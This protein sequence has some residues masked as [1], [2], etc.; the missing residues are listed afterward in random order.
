MHLCHGHGH[1]THLV[2]EALA[3]HVR[4]L[5]R[6]VRDRS[7]GCLAPVPVV[8]RAV[9]L[10]HELGS[11]ITLHA[12]HLPEALAQEEVL[13]PLA[14]VQLLHTLRGRLLVPARVV[15]LLQGH[16]GLAGQDLD[17]PMQ[18]KLAVVDVASPSVSC[19]N[20]A[21]PV[22]E[23]YGVWVDLGDPVRCEVAALVQDLF[24]DGDEDPAVERR[25]RVTTELNGEVHVDGCRRQPVSDLHGPVGVHSVAIAC[26]DA[27]LQGPL[28]LD[29]LVLLARGRG[30]RWRAG[31]A[32][33][34]GDHE[35]KAEH[36]IVDRWHR[37]P[38]GGRRHRP[39]RGRCRH[40]RFRHEGSFVQLR[41]R[42]R[43]AGHEAQLRH[44]VDRQPT[45]QPALAVAAVG[46]GVLDP[47]PRLALRNALAHGAAHL[48]RGH[49]VH[50]RAEDL[51]VGHRELVVHVLVHGAA[52][53]G[54]RC[55][56]LQELGP[57]ELERRARPQAAKPC[58]GSS[59]PHAAQEDSQERSALPARGGGRRPARCLIAGE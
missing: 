15:V 23:K 11:Q 10:A 26:E 28:Q 30:R 36:L 2:R 57:A 59:C 39:R 46:Q 33:A 13:A 3:V 21:K 56:L 54:K 31:R 7:T 45:L 17:R 32:A 55:L 9:S 24:P 8:A 53:A 40:R 48:R 12:V 35:G 6:M 41:P 29:E 49:V 50:V 5:E 20:R 18:P 58:N 14:E 16:H 4:P 19:E 51:L 38:T 27:G 34:E 22:R 47:R 43:K 52:L 25:V 37:C 1:A 44:L 42:R